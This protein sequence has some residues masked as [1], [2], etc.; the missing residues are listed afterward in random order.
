MEFCGHSSEGWGPQS[1]LRPFDLTPCFE[2]TILFSVPSALLV[3]LGIPRI[4]KLR[5]NAIFIRG[6]TSRRLSQ[7]KIVRFDIF[8]EFLCPPDSIL[9]VWSRENI[10]TLYFSYRP[11]DIELIFF[12]RSW[13]SCSPPF[14][15]PVLCLPP[16]HQSIKHQPYTSLF[17]CKLSPS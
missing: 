4:L 17:S 3:T 15:L 7:T 5:R 6:S 1:S 12:C 14:L 16:F 8:A 2:W 10:E 11:H 13:L 9:S